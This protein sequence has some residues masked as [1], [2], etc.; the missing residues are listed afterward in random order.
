MLW[1]E[2]PPLGAANTATIHQ[3]GCTTAAA[4]A[5]PLVGRAQ[6]LALGFSEAVACLCGES[7][8][9]GRHTNVS[10]HKSC[11][12]T[13]VTLALGWDCMGCEVSGSLVTPDHGDLTPPRHLNKL[14]GIYN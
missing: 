9:R 8:P 12:T 3:G 4:T 5:Q 14:A 6:A 2:R 11:P 1:I 13:G 10:T 7:L